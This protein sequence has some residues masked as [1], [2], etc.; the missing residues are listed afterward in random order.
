MHLKNR[1]YIFYNK[2]V[3]LYKNRNDVK[4]IHIIQQEKENPYTQA[5][6]YTSFF[7]R[8]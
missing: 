5:R 2:F 1:Q 6:C 4:G 7:G 3:L 8:V